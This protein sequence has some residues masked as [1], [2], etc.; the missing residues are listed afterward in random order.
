MIKAIFF[1]W[2]NTL[3]TF[4]KNRE[5]ELNKVLEPFGFSWRRFY[6]LW[7][8]FYILRSS[9]MIKN[10]RDF[11]N[12][13]K[14]VSQKNI[15]MR[16]IIKI[17]INNSVIPKEHIEVVRAL[18]K[19][20]KVGILSN[21]VQAWAKQVLRNYKIDNLFDAVIISSKIGTRKPDAFIYYQALKKL[22][23]R[24][25]ESVFVSDEISDDLVAATGL[26][27]KTIWFNPKVKEWE[28]KKDEKVLKIYKPDAVIKNFK[29]LISAINFIKIK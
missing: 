12:Y 1:D 15:P 19:K 29:E 17:S 23:V 22:A 6:P 28:D 20:Y 24:P 9:G 14:K 2:G 16:E 10:D 11:E 3:A 7:R 18:K 27:I 4:S 13:I 26:G 25:E 8:Q 5:K 21:Y